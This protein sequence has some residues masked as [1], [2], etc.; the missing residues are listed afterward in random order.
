MLGAMAV[1]HVPIHNACFCNCIRYLQLGGRVLCSLRSGRA[2]QSRCTA[3]NALP[4]LLQIETLPGTR[5]WS[6]GVRC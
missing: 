2:Q 4:G 3:K 5:M 6:L 1:L